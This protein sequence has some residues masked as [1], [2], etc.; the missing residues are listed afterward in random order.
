M[1]KQATFIQ[2]GKNIDC[3]A[4]ADIAVGEV[5]PIVTGIDVA[6]TSIANGDTGSLITEACLS[7]LLSIL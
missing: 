2:I 7:A 3:T 5:V 1:A 6:Q 4:S